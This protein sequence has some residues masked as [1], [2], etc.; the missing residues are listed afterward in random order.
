MQEKL[1]KIAVFNTE[2][3]RLLETDFAAFDIYRSK[4]L[5][6]HLLKHKHF[7]AAKYID[8]LPDIIANPDYVGYKDG[9]LEMVKVYKDNVFISIKYDEKS[10]KY[11]VAT[12]FDIKTSKIVAYE[13][14]GRLKNAQGLRS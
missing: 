13:K 12:I 5:M 6:T 1:L 2:L 4:G 3:N 9:S 7:A 11:Y 10:N 8:Y 14:L